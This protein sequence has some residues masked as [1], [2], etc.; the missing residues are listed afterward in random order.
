MQHNLTLTA[1]EPSGTGLR[2]LVFDRPLDGFTRPGQFVTVHVQ[3]HKPAYFAIASVPGAPLELLVKVQGDAAEALAAMVPGDA[4]EISEPIGNGFPIPADD[5][6][7]LVLLAAGS[8]LSAVR[9]VIEAEVA[10][11]LPR[12]VTLFYGVYTPAHRAFVD[13]LAAWE[14]AGVDVRLVYSDPVPGWTGATGFVQGAAA[15]AGFVRGD[16]TV[17]LC[18]FPQMVAEAKAAWLEAGADPERVLVNF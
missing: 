13:R 1:N 2:H 12:P 4:V 17:V 6:Q 7:P 11:G 10:A 14:A 9:S 16:V 3:G 15:E 5:D 8:G 18:G